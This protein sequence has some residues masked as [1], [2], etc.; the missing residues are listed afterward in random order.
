MT[1]KMNKKV[2]IAAIVLCIA[3]LALSAAACRSQDQIEEQ[4]NIVASTQNTDGYYDTRSTVR[5]TGTGTVS[6]KPDIAEVGFTVRAQEKDVSEAQQQNAKL[7]EAVLEVI[8][9]RGIAEEDIETGYLNINEVRDYSKNTSKVVGYEVYHTVNV[10]VRDM[11]VLG[12]LIS[13]AVAAGASDVSGPEYSIEDDSEAYLQALGMAVES[14][15]A[16]ARAIAAGAGVRLTNLP[17]S[18]D[19]NGGADSAVVYDDTNRT[20]KAPGCG[21]A[22]GGRVD[23]SAD[24]NAHHKGDGH[25]RRHISDNALTTAK[26]KSRPRFFFGAFVMGKIKIKG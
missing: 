24:R 10:K 12:S 6:I 2:R 26:E 5:V 13:E 7:M 3:M 22:R 11:D 14:A 8:K 23:R 19:E 9:A 20:L 16:K 17:I 25:G 4:K 21:G 15:G 18:I 1:M